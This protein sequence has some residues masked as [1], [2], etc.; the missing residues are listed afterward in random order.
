MA[1][2]RGLHAISGEIEI[3]YIPDDT[4]A[5]K[6]VKIKDETP[7][8]D[9]V[10]HLVHGYVKQEMMKQ[11]AGNNNVN[12]EFNVIPYAI[13]CIIIKYICYFMDQFNTKSAGI[14]EVNGN[15]R[16]IQR[17]FGGDVRVAYGQNQMIQNGK[18]S[19]TLHIKRF[20]GKT[21]TAGFISWQ[22]PQGPFFYKK[23]H[24]IYYGMKINSLNKSVCFEI[25]DG[26]RYKTKIINAFDKSVGSGDIFKIIFDSINNKFIVKLF[27]W[28]E[29]QNVNVIKEMKFLAMNHISGKYKFRLM[30]GLQGSRDGVEILNCMR[31]LRNV[32]K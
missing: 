1:C 22:D 31:W 14:D 7:T 18:Y 28:N 15:P 3:P 2:L 13:M 19:Y 4:I 5:P 29:E 8:N 24:E 26:I 17:Q 16:Y 11:N 10:E 23:K 30:V 32:A 12:A 6:N 25:C 20:V 9:N 21:L 27:Q